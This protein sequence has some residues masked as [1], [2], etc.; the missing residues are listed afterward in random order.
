MCGTHAACRYL[1]D[2]MGVF[3]WDRG[4]SQEDTALLDQATEP[5][6]QQD[7]RPSWGCAH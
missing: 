5:K 4:L 1:A 7:G 2:D 3:G 6:G